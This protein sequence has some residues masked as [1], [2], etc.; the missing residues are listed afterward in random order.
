[1]LEFFQGEWASEL[2]RILNDSIGEKDPTSAGS[3]MAKWWPRPNYE[4]F[5]FT[6]GGISYR[7]EKDEVYQKKSSGWNC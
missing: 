2:T 4:K 6:P 3:Q 1:M 5:K 7:G